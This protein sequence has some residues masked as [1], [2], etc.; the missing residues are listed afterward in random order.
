M[1]NSYFFKCF[2]FFFLYLIVPS[3]SAADDSMKGKL[4]WL[5]FLQNNMGN[6]YL[7]IIISAEVKTTGTVSIPLIGWNYNFSVPAGGT[8]YVDIPKTIAESSIS[9]VIQNNGIKITSNENINVSA[10]NHA[11]YT[12]DASYI[13]PEFSLGSDYVALSYMAYQ[14]AFFTFPNDLLIVGVKDNTV[15]EIIPSVITLNGHEPGVAFSISLNKG[16]TYLLQSSNGMDIT[17]TQVKGKDK[18]LPFALFTGAN[19]AHVPI[20][21]PSADHIFHQ[22]LPT[23][24]WG[25]NYLI[26]PVNGFYT[27]RMAASEDNTYVTINGVDTALLNSGDYITVNNQNS[28]QQITSSKPIIVAQFLEGPGHFT[29][30]LGDPAMT[31]LSP[32]EGKYKKVIFSTPDIDNFSK[33]YVNIV[34]ETKYN[35]QV[36]HNGNN[37]ASGFIPFPNSNLF[38]YQTIELKPGYHHFTSENGLT[39]NIFGLGKYNSYFLSGGYSAILTTDSRP[40]VKAGSD[41]TIL[42]GTSAQ[43]NAIGGQTYQW[44]PPNDLSCENCSSPIVF[45][46]ETTT[47]KVI[48]TNE[49]GCLAV[50]SITVF[51]DADL[52]I[53]IP[54]IFS[55]NGDGNNDTF[56]IRGKGIKSLNLIIYNRWGEKVF[57]TS[58]VNSGWDGNFRGQQLPPSVFVYYLNAFLETEQRVIKKGDIT[59]IR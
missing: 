53:Y 48:A 13:I 58:D 18:C 2:L 6:N 33:H 44:L 55:P 41:T 4:F 10:I 57:E 12:T 34:I 56:Y 40:I 15:I 38:S 29:E 24:Q 47:Y 5:S 8:V 3:V 17:G 30:Q 50:D 11:E 59:L 26:A 1:E 43:L 52:N 49:Y 7:T 35:N 28:A 19:I 21:N 46:R 37:I 39:C 14:S 23:D 25:K 42:I 22:M 36:F 20:N 27:L 31:I 32:Q 16:Q 54:N 51:V 45:P 9:G